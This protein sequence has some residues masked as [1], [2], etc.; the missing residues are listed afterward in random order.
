MATTARTADT[1]AAPG[2]RDRTAAPSERPP[3][4]PQTAILY[5]VLIFYGIFSLAPFILA[6]ISSF[7]TYGDIVNNPASLVPQPITGANYQQ[8]LGSNAP[9]PH[10]IFNSLVYAITTAVL[11]VVLASMAGYAFGR[12]E[13]PGKN[14]LFA[15]TLAVLMIPTQLILIPK[16]LVVNALGLANTFGALI[17]PAMVTPTSVFLMTQF[18]KSLPHEL[19]E[20]AMI[21]GAGRFRAFWQI[22]LPLTKPAI[23]A[24]ALFQFQ[25]AWN[26]FIWPLIVMSSQDNYTLTVGLSYFKGVNFI[27]Y[28]LLLAGAAINI[29]PLVVLFFIFQRYFVQGISTAGLAGR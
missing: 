26:D 4:K 27:F 18:M 8:I 24:V 7:K 10:Y 20:S 28:N 19:E 9:F 12:L 22:I 15:L 2:A 6:F 25:G 29:A 1:R 14:V 17:I 16:F 3:L 11:N 23:T 5:A 13:F 21:D